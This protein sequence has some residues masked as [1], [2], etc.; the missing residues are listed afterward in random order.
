[1]K[2]FA[3]LLAGAC[4]L[5]T[6]ALSFEE[7]KVTYTELKAGVKGDRTGKHQFEGTRRVSRK[8]GVAPARCRPRRACA[9]GKPA[10]HRR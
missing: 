7:I 4:V 10:K 6:P 8:A 5:A 9:T 3:M 1:M 2:R